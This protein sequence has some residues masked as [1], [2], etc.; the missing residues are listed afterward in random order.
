MFI[1]FKARRKL[2]CTRKNFDLFQRLNSKVNVSSQASEEGSNDVL[3]E[4]K[5]ILEDVNNIGLDIVGDS[6]MG[7]LKIA[8]LLKTGEL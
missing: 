5:R 7:D 3:S 2:P 8:E 6:T 4:A 1:K